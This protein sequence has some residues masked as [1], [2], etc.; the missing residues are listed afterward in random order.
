M[1]GDTIVALSTPPGCSAIAVIRISGPAAREILERLTPGASSWEPRTLHACIL[2]GAAGEPLDESTAVLLRAPHS[3][4]GE[5]SAEIFCHGSMVIVDR[6]VDEAVR[7]GARH[8]GPG[9]F[10]RRAF[11][12]GKIDL[13]QAEAVADLVAAQTRL[14]AAVA[15]EHLD[16][17]LSRRLEAVE[18][19]LLGLLTL[20]E[21]SI[22][23]A[24]EDIE[25]YT[26]DKVL[27]AA[28]DARERIAAL[29]E[30][31][32]AGG[33]LRAGIRIAIAGPRNAGKSSIYNA[34]IGEER[35]IVSTVPGTT[36]D[37]LRERIH[38]GGFTFFLEDTAGLG[39]TDCEIE[40]KGIEK[41][42]EAVRA[43]DLV[44]F[45]V[46]AHTGWDRGAAEALEA[47]AHRNHIIALN[48]SDLGIEEGM[49]DA[50]PTAGGGRI[51]E[52][53]AV[54]GEGLE[55]LRA[56]I[57]RYTI[58][59]EADGLGRE[60]IAVNARQGSALRASEAA[61]ERLAG[62]AAEGAP[63][64]ILSIEIRDA[65]GAIGEVTGRSVTE[66]V[67]DEIFGRF[68]IGK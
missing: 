21:A 53:S 43:A 44:V 38:I 7:L 46:D 61:L 58:E 47:L 36:R 15:L 4:T 22:D 59:G 68:C 14:Q 42:S 23:F 30:S 33:K 49:R 41:G 32:V 5:D 48:K 19:D 1:A 60:R 45:V 29:L 2:R 50:V 63:A 13:S 51:V 25:I 17:A 20:I 54:S 56:M 24:D 62:A 18:H 31:E 6:I 39:A 10:T 65:L 34:L 55:R 57:F 28:G 67:L 66:R 12:A 64:E 27:G 8:A 37:V 16:G 26:I 11:L 3:Y 52:T 40:R 35:A 9:E